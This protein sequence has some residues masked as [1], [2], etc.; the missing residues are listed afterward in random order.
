MPIYEYICQA[1]SRSHEA[2]Q[3][4]ND[5]PLTTCPACHQSTLTKMISATSFQLKGTGWYATS[6]PPSTT[7]DKAAD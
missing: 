5:Q 2:F 6:T 4:I 7:S 1:C 3:G